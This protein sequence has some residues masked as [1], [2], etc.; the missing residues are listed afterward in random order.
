MLFAPLF[1]A[2]LLLD[3]HRRGPGRRGNPRPDRHVLSEPVIALLIGLIG[4]GFVGRMRSEQSRLRRRSRRGSRRADRS[5]SYRRGRLAGRHHHRGRP[6]RFL[7][8]YFTASTAAPLLVVWVIA[9]VLHIA[10]GSVTI[11]AITSAGILAPV[12]PLHRLDPVLIALA[13]GAAR[14]SRSTSP[15]TPSGSCSPCSANPLGCIQDRHRRRVRRLR[16][17]DP[18]DP[19]RKPAVLTATSSRNTMND[20]HTDIR[21]AGRRARP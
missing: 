21:P 16:G 9:A 4:T 7:G 12:A 1:L 8:E 13:A 10:V 6:G 19:A 2:C 3:R 14:C 15:A 18:A 5:S 11:S 17:C 20:R